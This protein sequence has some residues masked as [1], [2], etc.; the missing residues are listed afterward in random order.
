LNAGV[1][2]R[3]RFLCKIQADG[4]HLFLGLAARM[5]VHR[6]NQVG[7]LWQTHRQVVGEFA[8]VA[9]ERPAPEAVELRVLGI[10]TSEAG[11]EAYQLI[12]R[13]P[14][15]G[16]PGRVEEEQTVMD[17]RHGL[18]TELNGPNPFVLREV[19][20]DNEA[21]TDVPAFSAY[22]EGPKP[23]L[24]T[25]CAPAKNDSAFRVGRLNRPLSAAA[26][27]CGPCSDRRGT[28]PFSRGHRR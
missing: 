17:D 9:A 12:L 4:G 27:R 22:W 15:T 13:I 19:G 1:P 2:P 21:A 10:V 8:G 3:G 18:W 5:K 16:R 28:S 7:P 11:I 14:F 6:E 24:G 23:R 20:R 26:R 25:L